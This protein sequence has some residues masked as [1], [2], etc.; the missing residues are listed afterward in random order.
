MSNPIEEIIPSKNR[1]INYIHYRFILSDHMKPINWSFFIVALLFF[2]ASCKKFQEK[3]NFT[4]HLTVISEETGLPLNGFASLEYIEGNKTKTVGAG[5][6]VNGELHNSVELPRSIKTGTLKIDCGTF[7][8]IPGANLASHYVKV[9]RGVNSGTI[10]VNPVYAFKIT[11]Y[12]AN[13]QGDLDSAWFNFLNSPNYTPQ[14]YTGCMNDSP[15][16][17]PIWNFDKVV[18]FQIISKK[19]GLLDTSNYQKVLLPESLN[20]FT[21]DY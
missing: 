10:K 17:L 6:I 9:V 8:K 11:L 7:Y 20:E 4:F 13:C 2:S 3:R 1:G 21:L 16:G 5:Q 12:N 19:N 14:L 15:L 18:N